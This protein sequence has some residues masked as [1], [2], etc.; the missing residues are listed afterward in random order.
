M[1]TAFSRNTVSNHATGKQV[2]DDAEIQGIVLDSEIGD[3]ADPDLIL[4]GGFEILIEQIPFLVLLPLFI[5]ALCVFPDTDKVQFLHNLTDTLFTHM[6]TA[7]CQDD[8]N[9]FGTVSLL[10]VVKN[11]LHL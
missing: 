10:A 7:F 5:V 11:L 6:D 2:E 9:L 8:P 3:V 1:G 4:P